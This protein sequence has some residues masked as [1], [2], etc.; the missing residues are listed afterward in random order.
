MK[1]Y[2]FSSMVALV[3]ILLYCCISF[4]STVPK[5]I[6]IMID[7]SGSMKKGDPHFLTKDA[8][9]EFVKKLSDDT[10]VAVLIFDQRVNLAISLTTVSEATKEDILAS[11]DYI[12]YKGKLTNIPAAMERAIYELKTKGQEESQKSIIFIL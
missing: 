10:Q 3:S 11:F 1:K 5:D 8:V 2:T 9:D 12:D 6:V 7:N 4:A